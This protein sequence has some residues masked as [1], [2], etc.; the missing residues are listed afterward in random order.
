MSC[1]E[2]VRAANPDRHRV[3][4]GMLVAWPVSPSFPTTHLP[5]PNPVRAMAEG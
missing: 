1:G 5:W 4:A 2:A 3:E